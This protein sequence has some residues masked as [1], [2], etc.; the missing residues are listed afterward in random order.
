MA[1]KV[2]VLAAFAVLA[3]ALVLAAILAWNS[4][5]FEHLGY[6]H[7]D[8]MY[9]ISAKSLTEGH[10]YRILSLPGTP[11]QTK[12]PPVFPLLLS[13]IWKVFPSF[14]GNLPWAMLAAWLTLPAFVLVSLRLLESWGCS[15]SSA[16]LVCAWMTLNPYVV[17][18]SINL[19]PE[20]LVAA[21][22]AGC[23]LA[24]RAAAG[25]DSS[26][27]ALAAGALGAIAYLTKATAIP[28]VAAGPLWFA[29]RRKLRLG[30]WFLAP[31]LAAVVLWSGWS[32]RH[33]ASSSDAVAIY[34]TSYLGDF[35]HDLRPAE[36]L[37][38]FWWNIPTFLESIGNLL[39]PDVARFPV[40][41]PNFS[42]LLALAAIAGIVRQVRRDGAGLHHWF[43]AGFSALLL[44]WQY[45]PNERFLIPIL[46]LL[47]CG[48]LTEA[49]HLAELMRA[50]WR[51]GRIGQR[52]A[53]GGFALLLA[54][55][56]LWAAVMVTAGHVV[57][58]P[59]VT[60]RYRRQFDS[61]RQ[62]YQWINQNLPSQEPLLAYGDAPA[63]LYTGRAAMRPPNFP[64]QYYRQDKETVARAFAALP[65]F[66]RRHGIRY[67]LLSETDLDLDPFVGEIVDWRKLTADP[68]YRVRFRAPS[69]AL[70]EIGTARSAA[71]LLLRL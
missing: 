65:E 11:Y 33:M 13:A 52:V 31:L 10:G 37:T 51:S 36:W 18:L 22:L 66:A 38:F 7:D 23:F 50:V 54:A 55:A 41:G 2:R 5:H 27:L 40:L 20:L 46:P 21:L 45:P 26:R 29:L 49:R 71:R 35:L 4:R 68:A 12:Y 17:F 56:G 43:A 16:M 19:M 3:A 57:L 53:A 6:F 48:A 61:N 47:A 1:V 69:A 70:Y 59:A 44:A 60:A 42:R 14:P 25:R 24:A 30:V 32:S 58:L 64:K 63:F 62:V 39:V 28:L 8:G 67:L 9:W 34:Y 15:R